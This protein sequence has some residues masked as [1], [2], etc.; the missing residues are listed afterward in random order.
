MRRT[1][2]PLYRELAE[3]VVIR[4]PRP[5]RRADEP[6]FMYPVGESPLEVVIAPARLVTDLGTSLQVE[7]QYRCNLIPPRA[8]IRNLDEVV[9]T[10]IDNAQG[11][12]L[13]VIET[14]TVRGIQQLRLENRVNQTS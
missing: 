4:R 1:Q 8:E 3:E 14:R 12:V 11:R 2:S 10:Q 7:N 5:Q 9:R 6:E 13:T